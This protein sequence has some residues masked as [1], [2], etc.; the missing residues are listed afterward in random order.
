MATL[1]LYIR[2][3]I[4]REAECK[5]LDL[6]RLLP[7][8]S[9]DRRRTHLTVQ[10]CP[11]AATAGGHRLGCNH[12]VHDRALPA[13]GKAGRGVK[14]SEGVA[15]KGPLASSLLIRWRTSRVCQDQGGDEKIE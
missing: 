14:G 1:R 2:C 10:G 6:S 5:D 15:F 8:Y 12:T 7:L 9:T 13:H 11:V 4:D 3:G